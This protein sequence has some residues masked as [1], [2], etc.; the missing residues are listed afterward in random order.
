MAFNFATVLTPRQRARNEAFQREIERL[1]GLPDRWLAEELLRLARSCRRQYPNLL[2]DPCGVVYDPNFVWHLV[3]EVA[4]RL[5]ANHLEPNE[6]IR[7]AGIS[8]P[9][10]RQCTGIY[11]QNVAIAE[12]D[13]A[14]F[15]QER[16]NA[17]EI[18]CHQVQNGNPVAFAVDRICAAP[19]AGED[20][21]D[22]TARLMREI[23]RVRGFEPTPHWSPMLSR[24]T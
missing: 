15:E 3:P 21:D 19:A 10:L 7:Y 18:L 13:R 11:L 16:P 5:G 14:R 2:G 6:G 9:E 20:R 23:S 12:W 4:K 1:F 24:W 22:L 8:A 17:A